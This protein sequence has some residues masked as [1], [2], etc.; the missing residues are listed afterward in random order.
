MR[1]N[2]TQH[3]STTEQGCAPRSK[4]QTQRIKELLTIA[5]LPDERDLTRRAVALAELARTAGATEAMVGSV[6]YLTLFLDPALRQRR[7]QP[8]YAFSQR[9]SVEIAQEDG[10]V[11]KKSVFRH[12]GFIKF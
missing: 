5:E 12:L 11:I 4:E 1:I 6:N 9:E 3:D 7:I 10:S 8:L 2:L